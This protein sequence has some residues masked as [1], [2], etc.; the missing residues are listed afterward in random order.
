MINPDLV[1][2]GDVL[3]DVHREAMG[4]TTIRRLGCWT[5]RVLAIN[6]TRT[7]FT[8]S[9]NGNAPTTRGRSQI[10]RLRRKP[11]PGPA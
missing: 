7:T 6:E 1:S 3:Y 11:L 2:V 10:A 8:V 5:V 4:S 9:W